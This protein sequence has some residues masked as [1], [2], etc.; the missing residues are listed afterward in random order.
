MKFLRGPAQ[1]SKDGLKKQFG[2][3]RQTCCDRRGRLPPSILFF[4]F[5]PSIFYFVLINRHVLLICK[6]NYLDFREN[7]IH[8]A[9]CYA[10]HR[11][12]GRFAA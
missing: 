10:I 9:P 12:V 1:G 5:L 8:D 2:E 3:T 6:I 11:P 7:P 4:A